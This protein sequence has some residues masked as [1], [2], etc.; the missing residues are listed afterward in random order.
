[1]SD[2]GFTLRA[3]TASSSLTGPRPTEVIVKGHTRGALGVEVKDD[4]GEATH[5]DL[6]W[7][8]AEL[9]VEVLN[10]ALAIRD[11]ARPGDELGRRPGGLT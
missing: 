9:L 2:M 5:L 6:C 10:R 7:D 1:M 3:Q 8:E 11:A 4:D